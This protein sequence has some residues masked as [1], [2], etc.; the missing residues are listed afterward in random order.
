MTRVATH[1]ASEAAALWLDLLER[2]SSRGGHAVRNPLN[3]A[4]V[5]LEVVRSRLR[6]GT[7]GQAALDAAGLAPFADSA[8]SELERA[9][10]VLNAVLALA[11]PAVGPLDLDSMAR[12]LVQLFDAL[13]RGDGT[14]EAP[15]VTLVGGGVALPIDV[16]AYVARLAIG[17]ALDA[18][19][20]ADAARICVECA[21]EVHDGSPH[22]TVRALNGDV[23][24]AG[25]RQ[26]AAEIVEAVRRAGV[27]MSPVPGGHVIAFARGHTRH[28]R[29]TNRSP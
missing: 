11:R 7:E 4:A 28:A 23:P 13:G 24:A 29:R 2:L 18:A 26:V 14:G 9:V 3:A 10:E 6:R 5:H 21:L 8:A 25:R 1:S 17:A 22:A 19:C 16:P 15:S 20:V 27:Q 12:P